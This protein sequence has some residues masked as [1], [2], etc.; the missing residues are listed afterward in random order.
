MKLKGERARRVMLLFLSLLVLRGASPAVYLGVS[1][2][3]QRVEELSWWFVLYLWTFE[4]FS[5]H[6]HVVRRRVRVFPGVLGR[7]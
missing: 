6:F 5:D 7:S 4:G 2:S 3:S 1:G